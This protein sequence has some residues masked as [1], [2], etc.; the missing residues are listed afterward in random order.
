[1]LSRNTEQEIKEVGLDY[2]LD[3]QPQTINVSWKILLFSF[4]VCGWKVLPF[5]FVAYATYIGSC[6]LRER[7]LERENIISTAL[8]TPEG[9]EALARAMVDAAKKTR[10]DLW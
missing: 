7:D 4:V 3:K 2:C 10:G 1:M 8:E 6:I 9:I 5:I